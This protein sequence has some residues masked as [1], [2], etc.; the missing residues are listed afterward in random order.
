MPKTK[1]SS[2]YNT[3]PKL[4]PKYTFLSELYLQIRVTKC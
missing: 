4:L 1:K 2:D 3:I